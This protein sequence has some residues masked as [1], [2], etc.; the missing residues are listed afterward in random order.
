MSYFF[1]K[2]EQIVHK[3]SERTIRIVS[4]QLVRPETKDKVSPSSECS[5][6][7]YAIIINRFH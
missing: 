3:N 4:Y 1:D 7:N 2:V 6:I 5:D